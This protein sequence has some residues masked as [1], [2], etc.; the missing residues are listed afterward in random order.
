MN[1]QDAYDLAEQLIDESIFRVSKGSNQAEEIDMLMKESVVQ[2]NFEKEELEIIFKFE[3]Q[4]HRMYTNIKTR[5]I[6]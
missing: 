4:D 5:K 3:L 6:H 2:I 1:D